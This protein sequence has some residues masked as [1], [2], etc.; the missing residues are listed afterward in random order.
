MAAIPK[1]VPRPLLKNFLAG[2]IDEQQGAEE[3]EKGEGAHQ[4]R[5]LAMA[6][7]RAVAV[8]RKREEAAT[9]TTMSDQPYL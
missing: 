5:D 2:G 9:T 8:R 4:T 6:M 1:Q 7:M 3:S